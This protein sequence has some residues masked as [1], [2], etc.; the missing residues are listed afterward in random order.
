MKHKRLRRDKNR[1]KDQSGNA[2]KTVQTNG[3]CKRV[4]IGVNSLEPVRI[5]E[6]DKAQNVHMQ[7]PRRKRTAW[8]LR[9]RNVR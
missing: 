4:N 9:S 3:G 7:Q 6:P 1:S 5:V 8:I 2:T